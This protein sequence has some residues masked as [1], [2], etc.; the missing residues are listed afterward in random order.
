MVDA[1]VA[2]RGWFLGPSHPLI[3]SSSHRSRTDVG[4]GGGDEGRSAISSKLDT[5]CAEATGAVWKEGMRLSSAVQLLSRGC[6]KP[7]PSVALRLGGPGPDTDGALDVCD[8][9]R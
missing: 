9:R 5:I 7:V 4:G 2:G 1:L 3:L 8:C 6:L